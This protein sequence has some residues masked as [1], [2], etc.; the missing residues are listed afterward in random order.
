M[1]LR[2]RVVVCA[3]AGGVGKT[4]VAAALGAGMAARGRRVLVLTID[5]ARRLAGALGLPEHGDAAH[6]VGL[7]EHGLEPTGSLHAAMLDAQL[8]FDRLVREQAPSARAAEHIL[9]NR[10]YRQVSS[11]VAGAHE[12]MAMERLYELHTGGDYDLIVLDTPP[13]RNAL[14]FLEAPGRLTRFVEGRALRF[15]LRPGMRAGRIGF[16]AVERLAGVAFLRELSELASGFDGMY[17]GFARRA[18]EVS[19][20]LAS[21]QTTFLLVTVPLPDPMAEADFFWRAL[22]QRELPF[23]GV[24]VNKVHPSYVGGAPAAR[25]R[26]RAKAKRALREAGVPDQ[27]AARAGENLLHYQ[28][29]ADRD[30]ELIDA[31]GRRIGKEP[32]VEVPLLD[33]DVRDLEGVAAVGRHLFAAV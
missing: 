6:E 33:H 8:T 28:A 24:I 25:T 31:L 2:R 13:S 10:I 23:G 7:A 15:L 29:L 19:T 21:R 4:T 3:G 11:A 17:E 5:P 32:V 12:Y 30:R 18:T 9:R 1:L 22:R 16:A 14:D 27:T 20:L 26:L